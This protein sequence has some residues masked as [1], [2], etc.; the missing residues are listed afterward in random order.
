MHDAHDGNKRMI[1]VGP[2]QRIFHLLAKL[3]VTDLSSVDLAVELPC[4][5]KGSDRE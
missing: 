4:S 1:S 2:N 3:A 5:A